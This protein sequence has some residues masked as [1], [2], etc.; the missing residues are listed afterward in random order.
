VIAE[1][2]KGAPDALAIDFGG[3]RSTGISAIAYN[4]L[5]EHLGLAGG[6]TRLYDVLQQLAEPEPEILAALGGRLKREFGRDL[7]FWGGGADMQRTVPV[8]AIPEIEAHVRELIEIFAPGGGYVFNQVRN[9][10]ADVLPE[11]IL[12]IYRTAAACGRRS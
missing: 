4:K 7:V 8:A 3:M 6:A 10:Q 1:N 2:G 9:I 12:A 5:K 11:K